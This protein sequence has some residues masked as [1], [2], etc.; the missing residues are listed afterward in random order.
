[1]SICLA[2]E[3]SCDETSV[4]ILKN[5]REVLSNVVSSSSHLFEETGGV[6]P[7]VAAR[8][9]IDYIIP[10]ICKALDEAN[11]K[12]EDID[13]FAVTKGPGLVGSL[14]VGITCAKT[15][16]LIYKKPLIGIN[17]LYGHIFSVF[18]NKYVN[19]IVQVSTPSLPALCL[20]VS[21]GH[22]DLA[23]L[24]NKTTI[25]YL[26]GT[27]DDAA[28][29]SFDKI[30]RL[31]GLSK[32]LGGRELSELAENFKGTPTL[33]LP[34]PLINSDNFDF[35]FSG[36]KTATKNA[37]EKNYKKEEIAHDFE[38]AV[39]DVL[40]KKVDKALNTYKLKSIIVG[41]GVIANKKIRATLVNKYGDRVFIPP[42]FLCGDNAAM[43]GCTAHYL[44][45]KLVNKKFDV[46]PS[47]SLDNAF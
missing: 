35:S 46:D 41:G 44:Y 33:N 23:I 1:M 15:L 43:I 37:Y 17:H 31:I 21:G 47:L 4:A 7:E 40:M 30:A 13:Y 45:K 39:V 28:G 8:A 19:Q 24:K 25:K 22:T 9:Q 16:A 14:L 12:I 42:L 10:C 36:L 29:E 38:Q 18:I 6:V 32:Y 11:V 2:I 20:V 3:S 27:I 5:G 26:G 34:R